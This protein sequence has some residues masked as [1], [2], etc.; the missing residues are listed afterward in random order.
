MDTPK[1]FQRTLAIDPTNG[2]F[3]FI[4]LEG[5]SRLVDWGVARVWSESDKEVLARVEG[6]V[7]RYSAGLL[8]VE[9]PDKS[10]RG[11]RARR[12]IKLLLRT[13]KA[14]GIVT[15]CVSRSAVRQ[16]V[17]IEG[18]TK[19]EIA[20]EIVR[21]FPELEASLPAP[22]RPWESENQR[23]NIFDALA[24]A[25]TALPCSSTCLYCVDS[26]RAPG[27]WILACTMR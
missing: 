9:D 26:S 4:V 12:L 11:T 13:A 24:L 25:L 17:G 15:C 7:A 3:A 2:G 22:R 1:Q 27:R 21:Y 16:S 6:I 18:A 10:R 5:P 14:W 23:M 19:Q 8:V 20:S